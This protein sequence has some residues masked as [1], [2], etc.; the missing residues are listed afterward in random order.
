MEKW[1]FD[2]YNNETHNEY[3]LFLSTKIDSVVTYI[4]FNSHDW[5]ILFIKKKYHTLTE[6][7]DKKKLDG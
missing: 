3:I 6:K 5:N 2:T 1:I 4:K 7:Y